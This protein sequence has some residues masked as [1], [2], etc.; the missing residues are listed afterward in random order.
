MWRRFGA[1]AKKY[2]SQKKKRGEA[3]LIEGGKGKGRKISQPFLWGEQKAN[4]VEK[5][6]CGDPSINP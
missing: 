5:V 4:T 3:K 1:A 2:S 6:G